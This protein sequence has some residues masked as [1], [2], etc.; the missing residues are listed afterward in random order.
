M[1]LASGALFCEGLELHEFRVYGFR[2]LGFTVYKGFEFNG[3][4]LGSRNPSTQVCYDRTLTVFVAPLL[5]TYVSIY[6]YTL[7]V[8]F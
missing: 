2:V 7:T 3:R 6:C 1:R 8:V 4:G 5:F